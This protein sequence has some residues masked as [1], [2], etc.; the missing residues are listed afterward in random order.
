MTTSYGFGTLLQIPYEEAI[1]LVKVALKAEGF[2][3][4][5]EFSCGLK[6]IFLRAKH[7]FSGEIKLWTGIF[8]IGNLPAPVDQLDAVPPGWQL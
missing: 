6:V 8:Q 1:Q 5:E 2:G 3:V 4:H 7:D